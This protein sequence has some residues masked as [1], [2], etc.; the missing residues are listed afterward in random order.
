MCFACIPGNPYSS[1]L[2]AWWPQQPCSTIHHSRNSRTSRSS[3]VDQLAWQQHRQGR[4][5]EWGRAGMV[6]RHSTV[7][8]GAVQYGM[9]YGTP[10]YS[11]VQHGT[12]QYS[13]VQYSAVWYSTVRYGTV[14]YST[15]QDMGKALWTR[16]FTYHI[17]FKYSAPVSCGIYNIRNYPSLYC[18]FFF[19]K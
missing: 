18:W 5:V 15:V 12:I 1:K 4:G 3:V 17:I 10:R 7:Q 13:T 9:V 19:H 6:W 14:R 8:L 11:T 16:K 2:D